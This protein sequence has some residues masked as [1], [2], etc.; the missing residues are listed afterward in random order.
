MIY[1]NIKAIAKEQ[2]ISVAQ[3][4]R[5]FDFARGAIAKWDEHKP[6]IERITRVADYLHTKVDDLIRESDDGEAE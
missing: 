3:I 4:E 1:D 5:H 2:G 6:S